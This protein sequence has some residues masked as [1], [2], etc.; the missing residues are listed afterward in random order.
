MKVERKIVRLITERV[1]VNG[2]VSLL[3]VC[4]RIEAAEDAAKLSENT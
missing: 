3:E 1:A 4:R 2:D